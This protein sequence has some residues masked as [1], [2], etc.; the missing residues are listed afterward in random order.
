MV[1]GDHL[2]MKPLERHSWSPLSFFLRTSGWGIRAHW[3]RMEEHGW[4]QPYQ[5]RYVPISTTQ[6]EFGTNGAYDSA[7]P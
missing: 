6:R 4:G 1:S 3:S 2:A 5:L 7:A